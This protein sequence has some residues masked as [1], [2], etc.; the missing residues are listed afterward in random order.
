MARRPAPSGYS[1]SVDGVDEQSLYGDF[2]PDFW[3]LIRTPKEQQNPEQISSAAVATGELLQILE[4][5]M[6][7]RDYVVG[8]QLTIGDIPLGS[9]MFK[10]YNLDIARPALPNIE[11]WYQRLCVRQAYRTHAMNPFGHSNEEWLELERAGA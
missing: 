10:Y 9:M 8:N 11:A 6:D 1:R 2:F 7:N 5:H 3:S 4:N